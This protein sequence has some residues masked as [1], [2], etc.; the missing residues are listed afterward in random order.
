MTM[1]MWYTLMIPR[2]QGYHL[3]GR[4]DEGKG[5]TGI[6]HLRGSFARIGRMS[7]LSFSDI[8]Q[9]DLVSLRGPG[10]PFPTKTLAAFAHKCLLQL[11]SFSVRGVRV[12]F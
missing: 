11:S 10:F 7:S 4:E 12:C 2:Y 3:K 1:G 5:L 8:Q 9:R 6:A